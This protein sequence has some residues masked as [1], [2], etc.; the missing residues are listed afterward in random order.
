MAQ[1]LADPLLPPATRESMLRFGEKSCL[2]VPLTFRGEP[3]GLLEIIE[4]RHERHFSRADRDLA[5][6][7][8]EQAG[9]A[10]HNARVFRSRGGT[11]PAAQRSCWRSCERST[12]QLGNELQLHHS[13]LELSEDLLSLRDQSAVFG[14]IAAALRVLV[15][16][17]S[18]E[19]SLVD[20]AAD[21]LVEV[22]LG[23]GSANE[24]LGFR[25]PLGSGVAGAV[26]AQRPRGDGRRHAEGPACRTGARDREGGAV[27]HR[28]LPCKWAGA[29]S[30]CSP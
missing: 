23:E 15:S 19:I 5:R 10:I 7:L 13:L 3:I 27:V 4:S 14:K 20:E 25:M 17:D 8:G 11:E 1:R 12:D 29:S 6:G 18:M 26:D 21:E 2:S 28:R 30:A 22:F 16:Y 9:A 24:T